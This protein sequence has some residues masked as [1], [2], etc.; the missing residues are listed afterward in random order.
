[1]IC[2]N[3]HSSNEAFTGKLSIVLNMK[4]DANFMNQICSSARVEILA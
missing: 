4:P 3:G 2:V 1:M